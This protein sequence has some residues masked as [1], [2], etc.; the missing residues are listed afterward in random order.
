MG[1]LSTNLPGTASDPAAAAASNEVFAVGWVVA[2]MPT[3][4]AVH[5]S[6]LLTPDA[7]LLDL[8]ASDRW[9]A[10]D[11]IVG[12]LGARRV[13]PDS[14]VEADRLELRARETAMSTAVGH[15]VAMPHASL[16]DLSEEVCCLALS[17]TGIQFDAFDGVPSGI[18]VCLLTPKSRRQLHT[19]TLAA[20]ATLLSRQ[21]VREQLLQASTAHDVLRL[22]RDAE[23]E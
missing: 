5:L 14:L 6:S 2:S 7:V 21:S 16:D 15:G 11:S 19:P 12:H 1:L 23:R 18:V 17:R 9:A 22:L 13:L 4:P 10:L 8:Q 20:A 3:M